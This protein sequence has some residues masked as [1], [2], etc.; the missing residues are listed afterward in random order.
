[1]K[2]FVVLSVVAL[3]AARPGYNYDRPIGNADGGAIIGGGNGFNAGGVCLCV[4]G[5]TE[6]DEEATDVI[7]VQ[8][9]LVDKLNSAYKIR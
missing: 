6:E 8:I 4:C 7:R 1:M 5:R 3:A 2:L 9:E